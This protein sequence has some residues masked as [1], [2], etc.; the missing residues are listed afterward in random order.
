MDIVRQTSSKNWW[1]SKPFIWL[2]AGVLICGIGYVSWSQ[3]SADIQVDNDQLLMAEVEQGPMSVKVAGNGILIPENIHW[4]ASEVS[5]RVEQVL[6]RAGAQVKTGQTLFVLSNPSLNQFRDESK[7]AYEAMLA[8]EK[9]LQSQLE[10]EK[11]DQHARVIRAKFALETAKLQLEAETKLIESG[12]DVVSKINYRRTQLQVAQLQ[13]SWE[14]EQR[15]VEQFDNNA[16]AQIAAMSAQV[17]RLKNILAR[18]QQQVSALQVSSSMSGI[19][20]ESNLEQGQQL[21]AGT[22]LAKI[23]RPDSLYA[24]IAISELLANGVAVG[25]KANIDTRNGLIKG[26]VTRIDPG[27]VDGNVK[28][29]VALLGILPTNARPDLSVTGEI[30]VAEIQ[31]TLHISRPAFSQSNQQAV[32]FVLDT[33]GI[34]HKTRVQYGTASTHKIE[35][36]SGLQLGDRV[37]VSDTSDWDRHQSIRIN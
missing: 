36:I 10:T 4:L 17:N 7:W 12:N 31:Q 14:I 23:A 2:T 35:I 33:Q 26:K 6:V 9:A 34:A 1:K 28:V 29:D 32:L 25:Q 20:Q 15:I 3:P 37:I 16:N 30:W 5:G 8:E 18:A 19:V 22:N 21:I 27:V 11:L 24:Q 13:Q